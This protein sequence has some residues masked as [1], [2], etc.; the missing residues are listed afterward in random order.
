MKKEN[1]WLVLAAVAAVFTLFAGPVLASGIEPYQLGMQEA[2]TPV[3]E[4]IHSF[5]NMMLWIISGITIFV[6]LLLLYVM[7]RFNAR[8]NPTPSSVTHHV[9]LEIVWTVVPVLI[10]IIV[11]IPSL[12]LLYLTDRVENPELVVKVIG[13]QWNWDYEYPDYEGLSFKSVMIPSNEISADKGQH[14]LLSADNPMVIPVDTTVQ[15][16]VTASDVLH[17]FAMPAF[18]VKVDAVPGRLNQTWARV[19]KTGTYYGQCSELCGKDHA[20]MPIEVRVVPKDDF[21]AWAEAAKTKMISYDDFMASQ[22]RTA[23]SE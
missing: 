14:R 23:A 21:A 16:I 13:N 15:F 12:K 17:S 2:V 19:T 8:A 1:L 5:H 22:G 20:F 4:R 11:A 6:M 18:G 9:P 3:A 7:I 10:L